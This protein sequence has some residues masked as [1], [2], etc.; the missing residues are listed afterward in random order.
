VVFL[1]GEFTVGRC[2]HT[3]ADSNQAHI[4]LVRAGSIVL[5]EWRLE[6]PTVPLQVSGAQFVNVDLA[7]FKIAPVTAIGAQF[8]H[9]ILRSVD[10]SGADLR[11]CNFTDTNLTAANLSRAR[12]HRVNFD[13]AVLDD[14]ALGDCTGL[15]F[16][17]NLKKAKIRSAASDPLAKIA[18]LDW[19][20]RLLSWTILR[21]A[22]KFPIFTPAYFTLTLIIIYGYFLGAINSYVT[23][24]KQKYCTLPSDVSNF[25]FD[26]LRFFREYFCSYINNIDM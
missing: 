1:W 23:L 8:S 5:N 2:S 10:L 11:G 6:N 7:G 16:S 26:E 18:A 12:L 3:L 19:P 13:G 22:G 15:A 25:Q 21:A 17:R 4:E 14:A 24:T 9:S 20:E